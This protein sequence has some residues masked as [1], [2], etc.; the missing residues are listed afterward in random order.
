VPDSDD[1]VIPALL[2]AAR[3]AYGHAVRERL[4]EAGYD[5]LPRNGPFVLGGLANRGGSAGDLIRELG[6][7][8]QAAGQL[9]DTL[10]LRG[11]LERAINSDDRRRMTI[12]VTARG[13]AAAEVVGAAV[14]S[15]D[16][17]LAARLSAAE[18]AGFRAGLVALCDIRDEMESEA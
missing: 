1:V 7:G 8:E 5:D 4:A 2:R 11:Y 13:R 17:E 16:T 18:L 10:V 6:V 3:G 12:E 9:I 14:E 15:V